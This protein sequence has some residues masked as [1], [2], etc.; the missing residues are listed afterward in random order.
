MPEKRLARA[1]ETLPAGF[2]FG[3]GAALANRVHFYTELIRTILRAREY[4]TLHGW[5]TIESD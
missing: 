1:R 2:Q 3:D 5:N 4:E